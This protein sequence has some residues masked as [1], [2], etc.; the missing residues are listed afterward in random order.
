MTNTPLPFETNSTWEKELHSVL[1]LG[2]LLVLERYFGGQYVYINE[3]QPTQDII[4][5]IGD[6]AAKRLSAH[7]G[8]S[9][10]YIPRAAINRARNIQIQ[11]GRKAGKSAKELAAQFKLSTR[12]IRTILKEKYGYDEAIRRE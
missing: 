8:G 6:D 9:E 7:Y 1:G 10:I 12:R 11:Q 4:E 2:A 5:A 3:A